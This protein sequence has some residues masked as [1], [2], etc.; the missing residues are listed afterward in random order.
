ME[1]GRRHKHFQN[2]MMCYFKK[3][4]N[5]TEMQKKKRFVQKERKTRM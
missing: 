5:S 3:G 2:I 4:K 1:D